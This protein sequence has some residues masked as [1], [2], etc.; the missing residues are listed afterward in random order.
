MA[1]E[2]GLIAAIFMIIATAGVAY[3][4]EHLTPTA[5][6]I[7]AIAVLVIITILIYLEG[8]VII[9]YKVSILHTAC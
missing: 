5:G 8:W 7:A 4:H 3:V 1:L 2:F 6:I 9:K